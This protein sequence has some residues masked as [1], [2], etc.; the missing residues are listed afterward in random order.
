MM[1]SLAAPRI[2]DDLG[3]ALDAQALGARL[4]AH[5]CEPGATV[6]DCQVVRYR[7][8][9]GERGIVQYAV[10]V[11]TA[12]GTL[13]DERIVGQWDARDR[14]AGARVRKLRRRAQHA[15]AG[16]AS[17]LPPVFLDAATGMVA[18]TY[19]FDRRLPGLVEAATG[20][21]PQI[22]SP[23]RAHMAIAADH[24]LE[25][26][27][28]PV[29]YREQLNAVVCYDLQTRNDEGPPRS[30]RFFVKVYGDHG[31]ARLRQVHHALGCLTAAA[32]AVS[33]APTLGYVD[34]LGALVTASATGT[35]LD[36]VD[37]DRPALE[38]ALQTTA[39]G[40]AAF[41]R[42]AQDVDVPALAT[43]PA[44]ATGR[45]VAALAAALP[46]RSASLDALARAT[47]ALD[48]QAGTGTGLVH[49][50]L[51]LEHVFLD[52]PRIQIIDL[53][54]CH[55]GIAAW[56]LALLVERWW[57]ARDKVPAERPLGDW[58]AH[59]LTMGYVSRV[60]LQGEAL[61]LLRAAAS[62]D[63]AAGLVKRREPD[64][65]ARAGRLVTRAARHLEAATP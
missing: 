19:P 24:P 32:G 6:L 36:R 22:L 14:D 2:V 29:R 25:V 45:S 13:V 27:V 42:L 21:S 41:G 28:T 39:A 15:L 61:P 52:G 50:D 54:S 9:P 30:G 37:L 10:T 57:A 51:K 26:R 40:L 48:D 43:A 38:S 34:A 63:V 44:S 59:V 8:R 3:A 46:D 18:T 49:G 20:R 33:I 64:W 55:R 16:W 4:H 5:L 60:R 58:G 53:D 56:D 7:H 47:M 62:L 23:M 17:A 31:G 1:P 11:R 65:Q 12:S 35:P